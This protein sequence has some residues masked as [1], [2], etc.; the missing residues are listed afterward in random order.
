MALAMAIFS[1]VQFSGS[2]KNSVSTDFAVSP[3]WKTAA[4]NSANA[5]M[6]MPGA[7]PTVG[8]V[9]CVRASASAA[10]GSCRPSALMTGNMLTGSSLFACLALHSVSSRCA[11][12]GSCRAMLDTAMPRLLMPYRFSI[13]TISS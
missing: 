3:G 10:A 2:A 11:A 5:D 9:G 12:A 1:R 8:G 13:A 7:M 4:S 6:L